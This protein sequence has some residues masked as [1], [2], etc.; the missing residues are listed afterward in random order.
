MEK[1]VTPQRLMGI[2]IIFI[3]VSSV[4]GFIL[5]FQDTASTPAIQDS[6]NGFNIDIT[7]DG[8]YK[9]KIQG[10]EFLF[11]SHPSDFESSQLPQEFLNALESKNVQISY[12]STTNESMMPVLA[13]MQ[14]YLEQ[15]LKNQKYIVTRGT[16]DQTKTPTLP[17]ITCNDAKTQNPVIF[18]TSTRIESSNPYC[19]ILSGE[20]R[21]L[22]Q[23]ETEQLAYKVLG[24]LK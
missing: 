14:Y 1:W 19:L 17:K 12:D 2:F 7:S 3:M 8:F 18:I 22:I 9:I 20:T 16:N 21:Q 10:Q 6:Y 11:A 5:S 24:V 13:D 23:K 4:G 15:I